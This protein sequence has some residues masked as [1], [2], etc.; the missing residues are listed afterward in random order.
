MSCFHPP[1]TSSLLPSHPGV[2]SLAI[3]GFARDQASF[4]NSYC[5]ASIPLTEYFPVYILVHGLLLATPHYI[6]ST[7]FKGDFD[8]FFSIAG[9]IDRLHSSETGEYS[10]ENFDRVKKLEVEYGGSN[11]RI[12]AS[13]ILKLFLQL[14]V[15]VGSIGLSLGWLRDFSFSFQCPRQLEEDGVIPDEWPLN[16]TVPCVYT[17]LRILSIVRIADFILTGLAMAMIM[18]GLA[19]CV[20][21]HTEQLG[22]KRVAKFTFQS[23][24]KPDLFVFPPIFQLKSRKHYGLIMSDFKTNSC[25]WCLMWLCCRR[26]LKV[27]LGNS[28]S[29]AISNDLDFLLLQLFRA[30]TSHGRVFRKIQ[31]SGHINKKEDHFLSWPPISGGGQGVGG[32]M[33]LEHWGVI[34]PPPTPNLGCNTQGCLYCL[35]SI[36]VLSQVR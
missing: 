28:V 20:V 19:W 29:P 15:C 7:I 35:Y 21:R 24:L 6:W 5:I 1:D 23:G 11:R 30:D 25:L 9:K 16:T 36:T 8:S 34:A 22:Y 27:R 3:Y 4:L 32:W 18:Y 26:R 33:Q 2:I 13:Y 17:S 14:L 12:F 10:E 31:V